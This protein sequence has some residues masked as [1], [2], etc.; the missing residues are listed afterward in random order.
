[1]F[2]KNCGKEVNDNAVICVQCGCST[3]AASGATPLDIS[4]VSDKSKITTLLL[5]LFLGCLGVHRFYV[6]KMGTGVLMLLTAGC[7]GIMAL[8]DL[9]QIV[10]GNF[11]DAEGKKIVQ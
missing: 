11:T 10:I 7:C 2:C 5:C 6:G 9:I 3:V 1:M 4:S 8:I